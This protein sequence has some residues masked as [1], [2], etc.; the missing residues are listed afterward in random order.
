MSGNNPSDRLT[1]VY[2]TS[3]PRV[4]YDDRTGSYHAWWDED[5]YEPVSTAL[6]MAIASVRGVEPE[7]LDPLAECIDPDSLN[8]IFSHWSG[9]TPRSGNGSISFTFAKCAVTIRATGEIIIDPIDQID[10]P[11]C[12]QSPRRAR[13]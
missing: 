11:G 12:C 5:G 10:S 1:P 4:Y 13:R 6:L 8:E 7:T 9:E 2:G 3:N